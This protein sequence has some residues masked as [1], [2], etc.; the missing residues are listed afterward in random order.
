MKFLDNLQSTDVGADHTGKKS[1]C[2]DGDVLD[3]SVDE[4]HLGFVRVPM[5][6]SVYDGGGHEGEGRHLDGA[7]EGDE[8]V[9]PGHGGGQGD[10][11]V[12]RSILI[13]RAALLFY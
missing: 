5:S 10:W 4:V 11:N 9:E 12:F 2:E 13:S 3:R 6:S 1:D 8:Q 7:E